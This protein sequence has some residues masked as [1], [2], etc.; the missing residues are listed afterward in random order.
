MNKKKSC[1]SKAESK[2][3]FRRASTHPWSPIHT[4]D[5][6]ENNCENNTGRSAYFLGLQPGFNSEL[7][8]N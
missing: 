4:Y 6:N 5:I 8:L 1:A 7:N 2:T 3:L